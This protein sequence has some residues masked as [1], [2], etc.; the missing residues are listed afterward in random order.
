MWSDKMKYNKNMVSLI[1]L[2]SWYH[3]YDDDAKI[4]SF[5]MDYKLFENDYN[6]KVTVGFPETSISKVVDC[7]EKNKIDYILINDNNKLKTFNNDNNYLRFLFNDLP[8]SYVINGRLFVK[9]P[10][11]NFTVKYDNEEPKNFIID[12]N[13]SFDAELTKKV[14]ENKVNDIIFINNYKIKILEKNIE[15]IQMIW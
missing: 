7:L 3:C 5:I 12:K 8:V 11:G 2:G 14:C 15:F 10:K 6:K 4:I 9:K 13:I 1:H